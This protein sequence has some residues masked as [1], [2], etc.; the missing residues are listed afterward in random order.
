MSKGEGENP[1]NKGGQCLGDGGQQCQMPQRSSRLSSRTF[2]DL[3]H[4][5]STEACE[6]SIEK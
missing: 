6:G 4:Q 3:V 2:L 1:D 5:E